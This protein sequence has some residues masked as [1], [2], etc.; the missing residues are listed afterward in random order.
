MFKS[1]GGF[2]NYWH[3]NWWKFFVPILIILFFVFALSQC[4]YGTVTDFSLLHISGARDVSGDEFVDALKNDVDINSQ[5]EDPSIEFLHIYVPDNSVDMMEL[6]V[7]EQIQTELVSG[8][9]TLF[10]V[11]KETIYSYKDD[12]FFYD[13]TEIADSFGIPEENRYIGPSG[14]VCAISVDS[15][16]YLSQNSLQCDSLYV[17]VRD[18]GPDDKE[19]YENA[20]KVLNHILTN[21]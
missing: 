4:S 10:V 16:R 19:E 14:E 17:A 5:K 7:L 3:Y 13:L 11:D 9:S 6:G 18:H 15:N 8:K 2:K 12:E 1:Y 21:R 20:F